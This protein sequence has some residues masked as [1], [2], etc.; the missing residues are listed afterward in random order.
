MAG[1]RRLTTLNSLL[2]ELN[3]LPFEA[4]IRH[5]YPLPTSAHGRQTIDLTEAKGW[6]LV[7]ATESNFLIPEER[8]VWLR[9]C[10]TRIA[11]DSVAGDLP[12]RAYDILDLLEKH[13]ATEQLFSLGVGLA[14][15]EYHVKR[16]SPGLRVYCSDYGVETAKRLRK[17]FHECDGISQFDLVKEQFRD[18]FPHAGAKSAVLIHRVDPQ[19]TDTQWQDAF[20]RLRESGVPYVLYVPHRLLTLRYAVQ[21]KRREWWHRMIGSPIALSGY[22]RTRRTT[23][24]FWEDS[25]ELVAEP[26]IGYSQGFWLRRIA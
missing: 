10:E 18:V 23:V 20:A 25:Y 5:H 7:R 14:A 19:L 11:H 13:G 9:M 1:A 8:T 2:R 12:S 15:L 4:T 3:S 22:V 21:S 26:A 24:R 17:V 6:D 16:L